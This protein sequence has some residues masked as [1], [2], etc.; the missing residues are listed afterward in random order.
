MLHTTILSIP[1]EFETE[2]HLFSPSAIDRGTL[3]MLRNVTL[4][5]DDI[6]LDL[7]CG[8]GPVGIF[9]ARLIGAG[10]VVMSDLSADAV[11]VSRRNAVRNNVPDIPILQSDGFD[12]IPRTDFTLILSNPPYH[13]DFSVARRF[14][15]GSWQRL[16]PGGRLYMVT[17]RREWYK[18]KLIS[19]FGGVTITEDDGYYVFCAIKQLS[20]PKSRAPR[21]PEGILSKKLMR[22]TSRRRNR[23]A[24]P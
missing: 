1:F 19:V 16:V 13:M 24:A 6:V 15:E 3:A 23:K 8:Y 2:E 21:K 7:G 18:N 22:K 10:Q 4:S 9:A 12:G 11:A 17:K 20:R 14:I 5:P